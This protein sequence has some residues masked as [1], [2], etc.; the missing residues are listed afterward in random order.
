MTTWRQE[1]RGTQWEEISLELSARGT[2]AQVRLGKK[3]GLRLQKVLHVRWRS[4]DFRIEAVVSS[5]ERDWK[6]YIKQNLMMSP[7]KTFQRE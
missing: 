7:T 4:M 2:R 3:I 1:Y 5:D 6:R